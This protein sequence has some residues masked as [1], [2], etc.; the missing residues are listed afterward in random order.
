MVNQGYLAASALVGAGAYDPA[1]T[2]AV[3]AFGECRR[4]RADSNQWSKSKGRDP[5]AAVP[6]Y[7]EGAAD[8]DLLQEGRRNLRDYFQSQGYFNADVEVASSSGLAERG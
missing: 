6:L 5:T 1:S 2:S 8:E 3:E 4:T 7:A